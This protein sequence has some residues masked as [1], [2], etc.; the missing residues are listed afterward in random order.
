MMVKVPTGLMLVI[1]ASPSVPKL[2]WGVHRKDATH[3]P[4]SQ[5]VTAWCLLFPSFPTL[6]YNF[7]HSLSAGLRSV[8]SLLASKGRWGQWPSLQLRATFGP[9]DSKMSLLS[10]KLTFGHLICPINPLNHS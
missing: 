2:F 7:P 4:T 10:Q 3:I 9:Q 6:T 5:S 8:K 1:C